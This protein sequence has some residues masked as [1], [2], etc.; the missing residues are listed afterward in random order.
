MK[1]FLI[2]TLLTSAKAAAVAAVGVS[3]NIGHPGFYGR[4]DV[5]GYPPPLLLHS[6]PIVIEHAGPGAGYAPIYLRV[7]PGHSAHWARHCHRYR[8]CGR[9]VY[10][11]QDGW[12]RDVYAPHYLERRSHRRPLYDDR[13]YGPPPGHPPGRAARGGPDI[14]PG[15]PHGYGPVYRP[16]P[17]HLPGYLQGRP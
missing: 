9:P 11:V 12:Y 17:G 10:F 7:P 5:G 6:Q 2:A 3:V 13:N 4:L 1:R 16:G 15:P 8:A 14:P